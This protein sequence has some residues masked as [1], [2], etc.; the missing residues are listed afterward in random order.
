MKWFNRTAQGF[1][2]GYQQRK[3]RPER[4]TDI[5]DVYADE[6]IY[7]RGAE[8]RIRPPFQGEIVY[9]LSPGLK[10]WAVLYTPFGRQEPES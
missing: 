7:C 10:P 8:D 4:A 3:S 9:A 1:S 2:P 6:D 5:H